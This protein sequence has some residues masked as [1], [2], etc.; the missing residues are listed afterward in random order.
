MLIDRAV[1]AY[2][3]FVRITGWIGNLSIQI[4]RELF[5]R[6]APRA[7]FQGRSIRGLTVEQHLGH[8]REGLLPLAERCGRVLRDA[9]AA[10]DALDAAPSRAVERSR[11]LRIALR[12]E[13]AAVDEA[14]RG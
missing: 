11:S 1:A 4:A 13:A 6:D 7:E 2:Y 14:L 5:G 9:L 8:L 10:L 3:D 12:L